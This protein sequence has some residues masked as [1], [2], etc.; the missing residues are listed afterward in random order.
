MLAVDL[1]PSCWL[2]LT[3]KAWTL[4]ESGMEYI[5]W[6]SMWRNSTFLEMSA[7]K[8][9]MLNCVVSETRTTV[10]LIRC[11][12]LSSIIC[13]FRLFCCSR[14][15]Y[16][17]PLVQF[18][19]LALRNAS[20]HDTILICNVVN[21]SMMQ[22]VFIHNYGKCSVSYWTGLLNAVYFCINPR[23]FIPNFLE[24]KMKPSFCFP[25]IND[26]SSPPAYVH[27]AYKSSV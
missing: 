15:G 24:R 25:S 12:I 4:D 19:F 5:P 7:I 13:V 18:S 2:K 26:I 22:N 3:H 6:N 16:D 17:P 11:T 1:L 14:H 20:F 8:E 27:A 21:K 23:L 9:D 10:F